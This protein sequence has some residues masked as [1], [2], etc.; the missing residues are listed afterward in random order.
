MPSPDLRTQAGRHS[1]TSQID[2]SLKLKKTS[3]QLSSLNSNV[4]FANTAYWY[5]VLL[6]TKQ[7]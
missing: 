3:T 4:Q 5:G 6:I 1:K 7:C 2:P